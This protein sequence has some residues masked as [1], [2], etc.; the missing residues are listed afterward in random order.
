MWRSMS[1]TPPMIARLSVGIEVLGGGFSLGSWSVGR[2][3]HPHRE[4]G[5]V[6]GLLFSSWKRAL[7]RSVLRADVNRHRH[8]CAGVIGG[9]CRG[10]GS[11]NEVISDRQGGS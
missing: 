5:V 10:E 2:E 4:V 8:G 6:E 11:C 7:T 1:A 3:H 9:V